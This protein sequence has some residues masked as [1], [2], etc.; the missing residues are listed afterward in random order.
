M[1]RKTTFLWFILISDRWKNL[2]KIWIPTLY[3][4]WVRTTWQTH[5][6][7]GRG[8]FCHFFLF[9]LIIVLLIFHFLFAGFILI[10]ATAGSTFAWSEISKSYLLS[11]QYRISLFY[12]LFIINCYK[13]TTL[14][15]QQ[16][17]FNKNNILIFQNLALA[18]L[19]WKVRV[20]DWIHTWWEFYF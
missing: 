6:H 9:W 17:A 2:H 1:L 15:Y 12:T 5:Q 10:L 18:K 4:W 19:S 16:I 11:I 8:A 13:T 7:Q 3:R 20:N 14:L